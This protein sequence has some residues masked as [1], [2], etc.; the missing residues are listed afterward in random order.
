MLSEDIFALRC[1]RPPYDLSKRLD[2]TISQFINQSMNFPPGAVE[3]AEDK[4]CCRHM[5]NTRRWFHGWHGFVEGK[6][7]A[8]VAAGQWEH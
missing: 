4:R 2:Y 6:L 3:A 5:A 8:P 1:Y 7:V